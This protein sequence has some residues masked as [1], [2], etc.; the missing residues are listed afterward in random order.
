MAPTTKRDIILAGFGG[1]GILF[2]GKLIA[3][4]GLLEGREVSWLPSY[5]PEMRGGTANCSVCLADEPIGSPL[6]LA[7]HVLV[8]L[9]QPS[10]DKFAHDIVPGGLAVVD[11]SLVRQTGERTDIALHAFPATKLAEEAGLKGLANVVSVGKL[12]A[13]TGFCREES[14]FVAVEKCVSA[15]KAALIEDNKKALKLGMGS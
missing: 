7:P 9:N 13:E 10:F 12:F 2:A 14:L 15:A 1:Q 4:A 11:S 5:G 3:Y 8:A 6:V